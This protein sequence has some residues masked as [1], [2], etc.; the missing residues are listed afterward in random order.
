MSSTDASEWRDVNPFKPPHAVTHD[1]TPIEPPSEALALKLIA[2][3][4]EELEPVINY[5][6]THDECRAEP[7]LMATL[8]KL[9]KS[10]REK[11]ERIERT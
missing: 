3:A 6:G 10:L 5:T 4:I 1:Y 2:E 8:G 9:A 7:D 11:A